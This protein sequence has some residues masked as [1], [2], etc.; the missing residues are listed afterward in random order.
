[1]VDFLVST[2]RPDLFSV[3]PSISS[4]GRLTFTPATNKFGSAVVT[5]Q[6]VDRG[7]SGGLHENA[8]G[9]QTF[10][11]TIAPV[12]DAPEAVADAFVT[13][14]NQV[15]TVAAPGLLANDTDVDLPAD[16][17]SVVA[18]TLT[19][20]LG[21]AVT[22]NADG[23]FTYD[24]SGVLAIQ[25]LTTGQNVVD[26]FIYEIQDAA[27][28]VSN[29]AAVTIQVNGVDDPPVA[30]DDAYSL[31]V[32]QTRL[33]NVLDND[34]DVD[35]FIDPRTIVITALPVHGT[36]VVNQTGVIEYTADPGFRGID[37]LAYTVKDGAGNV[38][39]EA[40]V[41]LTINS[42]PVASNDTAFTFKNQ[43]V[44]INVL[45]NDSDPDGTL[46]P[47]TVQ[48]VVNP[49]PS[50]T[51]VVEADGTITFT[52]APNFFG[53]V[54]FS[55]VVAD[56]LGTVSNVAKV[57][58]NVLN[59]RWQN[60]LGRLD[61]NADGS[62]SPIDALLIIN[63]LNNPDNETF[64][65]DTIGTPGEVVPPP[66][67]DVNGDEFVSPLDALQ[68]I[69]F[70]NINGSGGEGEAD[71]IL[72]N[73]SYAM[74]VT[75]EQMIATVGPQVLREIEAAMEQSLAEF[76]DGPIGDPLHRT[77]GPTG[78]N[79][80]AATN[81]LPSPSDDNEDALDWLALEGEADATSAIDKFFDELG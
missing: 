60:P 52:P 37:S 79:A 7:P 27:G 2:D 58:V 66:Y 42:A 75:P 3:T 78:S 20:N 46:D 54:T 77:S 35:T 55:Y 56:D 74:M 72:G 17:L 38:S 23:S 50:G 19:S 69:N 80:F 45:S 47:S 4:A 40:T 28:A 21:A 11:I 10:T 31:G 36:A 62:V 6:A 59:S 41:T 48:V 1:M 61:V 29:G 30:N 67:L 76:I 68:I 71:E 12:N 44:N 24:P 64:L 49:A 18:R 15:L 13:N 34:T 9:Q 22:L 70:L 5:V 51:A 33:L 8:S 25:Q 81:G 63:Y 57:S 16:T 32:G 53:T 73:S 14:E 26:S 43:P 39:N 65:P